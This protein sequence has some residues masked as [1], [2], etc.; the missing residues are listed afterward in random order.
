[1]PGDPN[2]VDLVRSRDR[3]RE[4]VAR[5]PV[6]PDTRT[7]FPVGAAEAM[8]HIRLVIYP[9]GGVARLRCLGDPVPPPGQML[10]RLEVPLL[11]AAPLATAIEETDA[12]AIHPGLLPHRSLLPETVYTDSGPA[13]A[14]DAPARS[15]SKP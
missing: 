3:W 5:S 8:T 2:I 10:R 1:M 12:L 14:N 4:L 13:P 9:D 7:R 11:A 6:A 15:R